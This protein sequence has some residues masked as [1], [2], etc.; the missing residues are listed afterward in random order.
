MFQELIQAR[1][2]IT[3]QYQVI[4]EVGPDHDKTFTV[5]L[6]VGKKIW[7]KGKG[8]SKQEAEERAAEAALEKA[9]D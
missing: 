8:K 3:P 7:S 9:Q 5:A 4:D 2:K 1:E 6:L